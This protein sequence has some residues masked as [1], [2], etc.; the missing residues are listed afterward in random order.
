VPIKVIARKTG[1]GRKLVRN[2]VRGLT[3]HVFRSR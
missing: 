2:V 1:H 3:V